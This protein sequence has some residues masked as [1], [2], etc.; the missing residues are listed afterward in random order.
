M[1]SV[2][3]CLLVMFWIDGVRL[4]KRSGVVNVFSVVPMTTGMVQ[5]HWISTVTT[6]LL[7]KKEMR[8][9]MLPIDVGC[10]VFASCSHR[11]CIVLQDDVTYCVMMSWNAVLTFES[12]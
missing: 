8:F 7:M 2:M 5:H 6:C 4:A 12:L 9:E 1:N 3:Q 11:V 10:I